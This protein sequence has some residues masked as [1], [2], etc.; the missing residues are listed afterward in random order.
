[1]SQ[2]IRA[3]ADEHDAVLAH[4]LPAYG[5]SAWRAGVPF[6][7]VL[8]GSDILVWPFRDAFRFMLAR[9]VLSSARWVVTDSVAVRR[10][11]QLNFG[12]PTD[13]VLIFP[14]GPEFDALSF[15]AVQKHEN[16]LIFP[17]AAESI[18]SPITAIEALGLLGERGRSL[19]LVFT[20]AG[21]MAGEC[22]R[23]AEAIQVNVEFKGPLPRRDYLGLVGMAGLYLSLALSD[24]TPVSLL[25]AMAMRA[26]PIV[27]DLPAIRD[28]VIDGING[29]LVDPRSPASVASAIER[30]LDDAIL[31]D[32]ARNINQMLIRE[33]GP[34][35]TYLQAIT[36]VLLRTRQLG[37]PELKPGKKGAFWSYL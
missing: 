18:Y 28:W 1:P 6:V 20:M 36:E 29:F 15:P 17:R 31:V 24:A 19:R 8:W 30:A 33:R 23:A 37:R 4:F 3:L 32:N 22:R 10:I 26:F 7:L 9:R 34:W 5:V 12:Y 16:L 35:T 14:F 13:R 25:E 2:Q 27:S 21:S 11:L